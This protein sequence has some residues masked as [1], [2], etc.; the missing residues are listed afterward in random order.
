MAA[1]VTLAVIALLAVLPAWWLAR[2]VPRVAAV[3]PELLAER[4]ERLL[5]QT[6]CGHC[7]FPG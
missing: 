7:G 2:R 6:L 1:M 3:D 4:I 5:P